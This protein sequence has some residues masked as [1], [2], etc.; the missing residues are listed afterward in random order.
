MIAAEQ[1]YVQATAID[2]K[3]AL[4]YARASM[5]NSDLASQYDGYRDRK[6]KARAQ[7]EEALRLS[8]DLGEAHM[9]RGRCLYLA[10]K[11][12]TAALKEFEIAAARS[13]NNAEVYSQI[14]V[15]YRRQ[16]RWR[17][18]LV[19]YRPRAISRSTKC[20]DCIPRRAQSSLRAG[21][22]DGRRW[23]PS[24]AGAAAGSS[25]A[26][27]L[28]LPTRALPARRSGLGRE[29]FAGH[30]RLGQKAASSWRAGTW[31]CCSATTPKRKRFS[32]NSPANIFCKP[33]VVPKHS[34]SAGPLSLAATAPRPSVILPRPCPRSKSPCATIPAMQSRHADLG[35][36]YAYMRGRRMP[37]GKVAGRLNLSRKARTHFMALPWAAHLALVYALTGE[38][39][40]RLHSSSVCFPLPARWAT[41]RILARTSRWPTCVCAGSGTRSAAIRASRRSSPDRSRRRSIRSDGERTACPPCAGAPRGWISNEV[42]LA[43]RSVAIGRR[44]AEKTFL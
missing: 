19:S 25:R 20:R 8:P 29:N 6:A 28:L 24:H 30:C 26:L 9:A 37:S 12:Y 23:I 3:F 32:A 14:G 35:L 44:M 2:P 31:R 7:A 22:G 5:L 11:D 18:S 34:S 21:L 10:D 36:L 27:R 39:D 17:D 13:P 16:G 43:L 41:R 15:I 42:L 4:A 1:L 40:R 33:K 38:Q